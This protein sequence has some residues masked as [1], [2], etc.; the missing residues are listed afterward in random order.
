M[1]SV[2]AARSARI[3]DSN[4]WPEIRKNPISKAGVFPYKGAQID[5]SLDPDKTYMVL[6]APEELSDPDTI[7]SFKLLPWVYIHPNRLLGAGE[8]RVSPDEKGVSGVTGEDVF[9]EGDTLYSNIKLFSADL[10]ELVD[11]NE[12]RQLSLG[13]GCKYKI[14]TGVWNGIPYDAIQYHIRGNHLASVP[15]GRMGPEV[16]VLD[17]LTFT[18]DARDITMPDKDKDDK[19][20]DAMMGEM[21]KVGDSLKEMGDALKA[22]DKRVHDM[23]EEEETGAND[24][25]EEEKKKAADKAAK[26]AEEEAKKK[27]ED[28]KGMDAAI[29]TAVDAALAPV[30][31]ELNSLKGV[32]AAHTAAMDAKTRETLT[33]QLTTFGFAIDGADAMTPQALR[34]AAVAKIGLKVEKGQEQIALDGF[35]HGREAP[36]DEV[37]FALDA[38]GANVDSLEQHIAKK[39]AA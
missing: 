15:E 34:E 16:A 24:E 12:A 38:R 19:A 21:K 26:D 25:S 22:L 33:S 8:D 1:P 29:K 37:G 32:A 36:Q 4:G 9:F 30:Q 17:H 35:F 10:Q 7:E 2:S 27:A 20:M 13:Y 39:R 18:V 6:R 5:E 23:E 14:S 11:S 3:P 28:K 31:A